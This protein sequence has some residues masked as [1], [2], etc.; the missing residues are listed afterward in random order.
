[1]LPAEMIKTTRSRLE[2]RQD[3]DKAASLAGALLVAF[4]GAEALL[5]LAMLLSEWVLPLGSGLLVPALRLILALAFAASGWFFLCRRS[6]VV[7]D[8]EHR[9][10]ARYLGVGGPAPG[11]NHCWDLAEFSE[12]VLTRRQR[13]RLLPGLDS[14]AWLV[15]LRRPDGSD[16]EL[17]RCRD[18]EEA[19]AVAERAASFAGLPHVR[20]VRR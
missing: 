13:R 16:L 17:Y 12:V 2:I 11:G 3:P 7:L 6:R 8:L 18:A 14:G 10:A 4:G 5:A 15:C 1:M 20:R 19:A 9:M